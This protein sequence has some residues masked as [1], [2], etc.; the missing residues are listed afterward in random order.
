M[1][2]E[3]IRSDLAQVGVDYAEMVSRFMDREEMFV[4]YFVSFFGAADGVVASLEEDIGRGDFAAAEHDAH[5]LKGL[6]GNIGL[7]GVYDIAA[8]IVSDL[9]GARTDSCAE[10]FRR[11]REIYVRAQEISQKM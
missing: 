2:D 4:R 5:A 6:A 9:R 3:G 11:L 1:I 8:K 10:D 7:N